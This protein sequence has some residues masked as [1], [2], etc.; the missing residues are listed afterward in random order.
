MYPESPPLRS[1]LVRVPQ[2]AKVGKEPREK[3]SQKVVGCLWLDPLTGVCIWHPALASPHPLLGRLGH[4][5]IPVTVLANKINNIWCKWAVTSSFSSPNTASNVQ[6]VNLSSL[7]GKIVQ[8]FPAKVFA[9]WHCLGLNY[10]ALFK[11][12]KLRTSNLPC[13]RPSRV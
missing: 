11:A 2:V 5:S 12:S 4:S 9:S 13:Q 10:H 8:S 3:A 6:T 1:W 7:P